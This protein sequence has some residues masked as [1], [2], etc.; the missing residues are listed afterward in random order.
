[1]KRS[2]KWNIPYTLLRTQKWHHNN[3][4]ERYRLNFRCLRQSLAVSHPFSRAVVASS[5][6]TTIEISAVL[7]SEFYCVKFLTINSLRNVSKSLAGVRLQSAVVELLSLTYLRFAVS[8]SLKS[9]E[10]LRRNGCL[11]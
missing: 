11:W 4:R 8:F 2:G 1:M 10:Y 9:F 7:S 5:Y 3:R 6:R